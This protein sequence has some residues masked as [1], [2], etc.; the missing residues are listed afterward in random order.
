[1][2]RIILLS[3]LAASLVTSVRGDEGSMEDKS[4]YTLFNPTPA[5]SL[6]VWRTDHAGVVPFTIDAGHVEVDV[7]AVSYGH[8]DELVGFV[9]LDGIGFVELRQKLEVWR[10]GFTQIKIGLLNNLDAE[11]TI[12]PYETITATVQGGSFGPFRRTL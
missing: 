5:D 2:K 9:F 12:E 11:V 4:H 6:R 1:M 10:Y 8:D 3:V 7:T